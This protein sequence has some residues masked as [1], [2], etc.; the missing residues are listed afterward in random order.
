MFLNPNYWLAGLDYEY[1]NEN[2]SEDKNNDE[3][4]SH[5]DDIKQD[6]GVGVE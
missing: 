1:K 6:E 3:Q 4:N 5:K 2:E